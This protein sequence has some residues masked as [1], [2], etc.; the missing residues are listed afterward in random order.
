M[1]RL[2]RAWTAAA[3]VTALLFTQL[4]I[5]ALPCAG[6]MPAMSGM[7]QPMPGCDQVGSGSM[8]L[9]HHHCEQAAQSFDK[10]EAPTVAPAPLMEI[11]PTPAVT[12]AM[13]RA[14]SV[15]PL[16]LVRATHPPAPPPNTC[17][18]I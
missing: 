5:A 17:L 7:E 4:A 9:C 11:S 2:V 15:A 10:A 13:A 16:L 18:R 8:P 6:T 12:P 3:T 14:L 1:N